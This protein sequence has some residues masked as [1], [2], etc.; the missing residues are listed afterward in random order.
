M[1]PSSLLHDFGAL[2]L[3][4]YIRNVVLGAIFSPLGNFLIAVTSPYTEALKLLNAG[5]TV[6]E[7]LANESHMHCVCTKKFSGY[8]R[9]FLL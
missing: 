2:T 8:S 1:T 6:K 5:I 3:I 7:V 4:S 9:C